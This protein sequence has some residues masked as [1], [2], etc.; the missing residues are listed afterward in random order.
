MEK[1]R[2]CEAELPPGAKFCPEC[3]ANVKKVNSN[4]LLK[5]IKQLKDDAV[6]MKEE[7]EQLKKKSVIAEGSDEEDLF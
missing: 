2:N 3:S 5:D 7:I 1:C 4:E 6:K